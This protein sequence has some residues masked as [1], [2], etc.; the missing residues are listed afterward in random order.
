MVLPGV[1]T[2]RSA[3]RALDPKILGLIAGSIGLGAIVVESGLAAAIADAIADLSSGT[4]GLVIVLALATTVM[5]NLVTNAA[6]ASIITPVALRIAADLGVDP[7]TVL[8]LIGT[9]VSFTLINPTAI[10][11]T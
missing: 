1:I 9:C 2:P 5:T 8:V 3:A 11:P 6:T 10:S 7:V 4:L